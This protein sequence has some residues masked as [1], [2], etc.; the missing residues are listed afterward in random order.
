MIKSVLNELIR[1]WLQKELYTLCALS[2]LMLLFT[3]QESSVDL[4]SKFKLETGFPTKHLF[5]WEIT[6]K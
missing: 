6:L 5:D 2:C 4:N 1:I 3:T